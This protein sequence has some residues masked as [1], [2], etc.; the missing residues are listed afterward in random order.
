MAQAGRGLSTDL[1]SLRAKLGMQAG[2][3]LRAYG[4]QGLQEQQTPYVKKGKEGY[5]SQAQPAAGAA[6][7]KW[8]S[9]LTPQDATD[10][11]NQFKR[12]I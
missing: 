10:F 4:Q 8:L 2:Q 1:A 7:S 5:A 3:E 6:F 11:M 9:S 12:G